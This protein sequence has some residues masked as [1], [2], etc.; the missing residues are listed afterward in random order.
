MQSSRVRVACG[1]VGLSLMM[2]SSAT[3]PAQAVTQYTGGSTSCPP[4]QSVWL[5]GEPA[6]H[7]KDTIKGYAPTSTLVMSTYDY[8]IN[9]NTKRQ[10]TSWRIY[11]ANGVDAATSHGYCA[12]AN[13]Q[14]V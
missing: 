2:A 8:S 9:H 14:F 4:G 13:A 5:W 6:S 1:V 7:L 12:P 11:F 10:S 3:T